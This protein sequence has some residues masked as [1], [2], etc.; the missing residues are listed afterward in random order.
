MEKNY[1]LHKYVCGRKLANDPY[2]R[3]DGGSLVRILED[4]DTISY[5]ELC[6]IVQKG[7]GYHSLLSVHYYILG[8]RSFDDGLILI[9][10]DKTTLDMLNLW[11]KNKVIDLYVEHEVDT[12]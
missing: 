2:L 1:V 11:Y 9:W 7:L 8:R 3:Y 4:P 10:N 5:Y 6:N 12:P